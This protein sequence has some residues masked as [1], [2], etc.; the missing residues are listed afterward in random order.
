[1]LRWGF[2]GEEGR[3]RGRDL[4]CL[5]VVGVVWGCDLHCMAWVWFGGRD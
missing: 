2:E 4:C 1:M 3:K 5:E